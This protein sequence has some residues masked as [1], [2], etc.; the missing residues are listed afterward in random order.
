MRWIYLSPHLDD[1]VFSAGGLIYKQTCAGIPVEIWTIMSGFPGDGEWT[2]FVNSLH[3]AWGTT[4]A[5]ETLRIRRGE[6]EKA[7]DILGVKVVDLDFIDSMYRR[8]P[9]GKAL[10]SN[11]FM[12]PHPLDAG[13]PA[14]IAEELARHIQTD[15]VVVCQLALGKHVDH[16]IARQAAELLD[17]PLTYLADFP[18]CLDDPLKL[19][20]AALRMKPSLHSIS[21]DGLRRWLDAM[22]S[23][24]SQIKV[25][26]GN[27]ERLEAKV[28]KYWKQHRG[29]R[30]WKQ[31]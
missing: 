26:F 17:R 5:D 3:R 16:V 30:L 25:E 8:G 21:E 24:D 11:S 13:L 12:Q 1:A 6:N 2:D 27:I 15:D 22:R 28:T 18:Y 20:C 29:I 9:D 4:S 10:Y 19:W 14:R 31:R 23:Y 7:A